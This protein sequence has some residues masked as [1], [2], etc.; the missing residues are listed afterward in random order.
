M[1]SGEAVEPWEGIGAEVVG[2]GRVRVG[3]VRG[4]AGGGC[5]GLDE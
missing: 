4:G 2:E 3:V 5:F 1:G